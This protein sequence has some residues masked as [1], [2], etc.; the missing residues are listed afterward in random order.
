MKNKLNI[1]P[2]DRYNKLTIIKEIPNKIRSFE[3][4]CDCGLD[5]IN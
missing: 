1:L 2:G 4:V 5:K 3:C